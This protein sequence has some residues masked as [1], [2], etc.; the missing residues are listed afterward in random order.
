MGFFSF[1]S[2]L[3]TG[4]A[5]PP[6]EEDGPDGRP[7]PAVGEMPSA[8]GADSGGGESRAGPGGDGPAV[9][10]EGIQPAHEE[11]PEGA[12]QEHAEEDGD[13][14]GR[15]ARKRET[16]RKLLEELD[17]LLDGDD[18][19]GEESFA[20]FG[21][22]RDS[23][24]APSAGDPAGAPAAPAD[25][26][27]PAA[28]DAA[29]ASGEAPA[30]GEA[31]DAAGAPD[32]EEEA[33]R[34]KEAEGGLLRQLGSLLG[35]EGGED[36]AEAEAKRRK[37]EEERLL[38]ELESMLGGDGVEGEESGGARGSEGPGRAGGPEDAKA[39]S[40]PASAGSGIAG[41]DSA[42][43]DSSGGPEPPSGPAP[44][45]PEEPGAA[46]EPGS[47]D[48]AGGV[49]GASGRAPTGASAGD[50]GGDGARLDE[51]PPLPSP[52]TELGQLRALLLEREI[53]QI[54][55]LE[56]TVHDSQ[57]LAQAISNIITEALLLRSK[58]D[59]KL[60][61][62]LGP[63]VE[64]IVTSSVRRSPETIA[65][66]IFPVIGPAIRRFISDTFVSMLQS[67][68]STLEMSLSLK[69]L[70]WRL[71]A[72][73]VHKPFSEIVMLHTL[74]YHVEEIY[75]IHAESG[76]IL[77]HIIYEGGE[78]RDAE[79]VAAM[80]TAIRDFIRDSFSVGQK[81][82]LDNL[83][84]GERTIFLQRTEQVF[85]AAVVRGNPP[86]ALG[87]DLQDALELMAVNS[88]EDLN[89]F[90]GDP[91]PFK[92]NR[93]FFQP[94]LEARFE[95]RSRK[96]PLIIRFAPLAAVLLLAAFLGAR[97]MDSHLARDE[98]AA[99]QAYL[100]DIN[101][102]RDNSRLTMRAKADRV[103]DRLGAEPGLSTGGMRELPG[104]GYE[105]TVFK[106]DL[107]D[108]PYDVLRSVEGVN[109]DSF[110]L[111]IAPYVSTDPEIISRKVNRFV[112]VPPGIR[113]S[114]DN[115]TGTL[116]FTGKASRGWTQDA[117]PQALSI[118]GVNRVDVSGVHDPDNEAAQQLQGQIN[119]TVIHFP[120]GGAQPVP[121]DQHDFE[122][123]I[124]KL[125]ALDILA[126]KMG[127]AVTLYLYGHADCVGSDIRNYDLS[128]ERTKT[129]ASRLYVGGSRMSIV[130][131][132][133]GSDTSRA[134]AAAPEEPPPPPAP[135]Q[136]SRARDAQPS[137]PGCPYGG[138][139]ESRKLEF[140][141]RL[142]DE[143]DAS[144]PSADA[145]GQARGAE[146]GSGAGAGAAAPGVPPSP[147]ANP[148]GG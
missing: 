64:T 100:A 69:G 98:S 19:D 127:V 91:A 1:F 115:D 147:P 73:K 28:P 129:V 107:A 2:R 37:A 96:L 88:A 67:L 143:K 128:L 112:T 15:E 18:G 42:G 123:T 79:L 102:M 109:P 14:A 121:E 144:L 122:E 43:L 95:E 31:P 134:P 10:L 41:P 57:A 114:F 145:S 60:L 119:G 131:Y 146:A 34:R 97:A 117:Q 74:L 103:A 76:L 142:G 49:P 124:K 6:S 135:R 78:S 133:F 83:R 11:E 104:V 17:R 3:K 92:K 87:R 35:R 68:N 148:A 32:P 105:I 13:E 16:E 48:L 106:D 113:H 62:V 56:G 61:T 9:E 33:R 116:S 130:N 136:R 12:W 21:E 77:D 4:A 71:E 84:F 5:Q 29:A 72:W 53:R 81:E 38:N 54:D 20:I 80:F 36:P 108:D 120:M 89:R 110:K 65:N 99:R 137:V 47:G 50:S 111:A 101:A 51:L 59:D 75:L 126:D 118:S 141:V 24:S 85:M 7:H 25:S 58:R 125:K 40:A 45:S 90:N 66:Q 70:K 22:D 132:N 55:R 39:P 8:Q 86:A 44:N 63:T 139:P 93:A 140:R 26:P 138:D 23:A 52:E 82:H 46:E 27:G 94:F 30:Y